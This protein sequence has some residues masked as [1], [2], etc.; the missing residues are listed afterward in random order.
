MKLC[1]KNLIALTLVAAFL[2]CLG[3]GVAPSAD[4]DNVEP[5][6]TDVPSNEDADETA[7]FELPVNVIDDKYRNWYEI[8][9]YSFAD[10]DDDDRIGDFVGA[11]EKL[12]Y[13][14]ELGVNGIWLMPIMPSPSYHKYDTTDYCDID[15]QYGTMDDFK[16]FLMTAHELGIEVIIDL[17]VNHT[18]NEHPWFQSARNDVNSPY[19][20][21]YNFSDTQSAG[22]NGS[23]GNYYESRFVASM[24]DLNLDNAEVRA[25]IADI[26]E[27]WLCDIGVDGFRLDAVTSYYTGFAS[28]NVAFLTW[29]NDTAKEL[30]PDCF[31]VGECWEDMYE[32]EAYYK[33]GI[34]S[35]FLFPTAQNSGYIAKILG[36]DVEK[37]GESFGN[38]VTLLNERFSDKIMAPFLGNHDTVRIANYLGYNNPT[39]I[40]MA[41]GLLAMLNGSIFIYY[42]DEI[43]MVGIGNDPNKRVGMYWDSKVTI[44]SAPPGATAADY[45]FGSV[46]SQ[47]ADANSILSYYKQAL[48]LRNAYPSIARGTPEV[49]GQDDVNVCVIRKTYGDETILI[50][51]NLNI[52]STSIALDK[53]VYEVLSFGGELTVW[54]NSVFSESDAFYTL[55]IPA[56]SIA[57][58]TCG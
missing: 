10:S 11:T 50:V 7:S 31:I 22:Y 20:D 58:L 41:F 45:P 5:A 13:L 54:G 56:Y 30:A 17:V 33:S 53:E 27:F 8:F 36:S 29:L 21:W 4:T 52:D 16:V 46:E 26:M 35:F 48:A 12:P 43:G 47:E 39:N 32:I 2:L 15:P 19:R 24:P 51:I 9:V 55:S 42:G 44:T 25:E 28:Q 3:C 49:I 6:A 14:A 38:V 34:D 1:Y 23:E 18:S 40:K 37:K 57:I